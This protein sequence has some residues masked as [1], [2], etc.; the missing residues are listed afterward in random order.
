MVYD[1]GVADAGSG[2]ILL[3]ALRLRAGAVECCQLRMR[4][5]RV[6]ASQ[7]ARRT[8]RNK[9]K[10]EKGKAGVHEGDTFVQPGQF[11]ELKKVSRSV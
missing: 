11:R 4:V 8:R 3:F 1:A 5:L 9:A 2:C 10:A 7:P 6:P